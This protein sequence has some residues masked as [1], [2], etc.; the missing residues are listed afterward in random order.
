[1]KKLFKTTL[2]I[3]KSNK[4]K[5]IF[6]NKYFTTNIIKLNN[7]EKNTSFVT[8]QLLQM[9]DKEIYSKVLSEIEK[10]VVEVTK[11]DGYLPGKNKNNTRRHSK[12]YNRR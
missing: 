8:P 5:T 10:V 12:F 9:E 6:I 2:S 1:M 7:E 4:I 3:F 11:E